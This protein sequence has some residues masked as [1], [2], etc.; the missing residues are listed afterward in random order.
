MLRGRVA[1][2]LSYGVGVRDGTRVSVGREVRDGVAVRDGVG[3]LVSVDVEE[4]VI[5]KEGVLV[6]IAVGESPSR[7][8]SPTTFNS[9]PTKICTW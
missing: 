2:N 8:N 5:V 7:T 9:N 1:M 4:G 6:G 3:V